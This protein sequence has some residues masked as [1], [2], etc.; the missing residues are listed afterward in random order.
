MNKPDLSLQDKSDFYLMLARAFMA[1]MDQNTYQAIVEFLADDLAELDVELGYGLGPHIAALR[2]QLAKVPSQEELLIIYSRIFL[3]PPREAQINPGMYLDGALMGGTVAEM[4]AFY[5][6]FNVMRGEHF[7]DLPD[8]VAIQLEFVAYLYARAA[9]A[10]EMGRHDNE[11]EAGAGHFLF[12]FVN[13]W[14]PKFHAD[15][16]KVTRELDEIMLPANPYLPLA[17]ILGDAAARD[18]L[19]NPE[20]LPVK[21]RVDKAI[22]KARADYAARGITE[23]D[24]AEME[25]KLKEKGLSVDHLKIPAENRDA[26][27]GWTAKTPPD[28]RRK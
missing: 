14:M 26:V 16:E 5:R 6:K 17:S 9:E 20:W 22:D 8:H 21:K 4:E 24:M 27:M 13:R 28:P 12:Q 15:L 18:A 2:E 3:Q 25:R 10:R 23:E 1:P 11:A 19:A 7:R